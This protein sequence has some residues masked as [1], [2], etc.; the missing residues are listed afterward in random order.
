MSRAPDSVF[1]RTNSVYNAHGLT[2]REFFAAR[3]PHTIPEWF[4]PKLRQRPVVPAAPELPDHE[5]FTD[6][7]ARN[8]IYNIVEKWRRDYHQGHVYSLGDIHPF[9][10]SV[11]TGK[12]AAL[13]KIARPAL[14]MF[15]EYWTGYRE[16]IE[17]WTIEREKAR[18]AQWPWT[19]SD[20]V[21]DAEGLLKRAEDP[22]VRA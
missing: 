5:L 21:L 4:E 6:I 8:Y 3:A 16:D 13:I 15:E 1:P 22:G 10:D 11:D 2:V 9:P 19:W 18:V 12:L 14:V 20:M 7:S 17:K